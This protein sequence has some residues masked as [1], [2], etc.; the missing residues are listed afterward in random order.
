M[1]RDAATV[2]ATRSIF[3]F[4]CAPT[5]ALPL[6]TT[7]YKDATIAPP[8][9]HAP[10]RTGRSPSLDARGHDGLHVRR[11]LVLERARTR[12]PLPP[13]S[14]PLCDA[15]RRQKTVFAT[16]ATRTVQID[17][18]VCDQGIDAVTG[19]A[20]PTAAAVDPQENK[21]KQGTSAPAVT[22]TG[23]TTTWTYQ[24]LPKPTRN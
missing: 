1:D 24:C 15:Q 12:V 4:Y 2:P 14:R 5:P 23:V 10:S 16:T 8:G 6:S 3:S 9:A 19:Q 17:C 7:T 20:C 13:T 11:G 18:P 21:E 22:A